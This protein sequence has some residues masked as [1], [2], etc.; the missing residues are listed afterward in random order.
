MVLRSLACA[1]LACACLRP[2]PVVRAP[3]PTPAALLLVLDQEHGGEVRDTPESL[4]ELVTAELVERNLVPEVASVRGRG[5]EVVRDSERRLGKLLLGG[6][7]PLALLVETKAVY[8]SPMN[9]RYRWMVHTRLTAAR[10]DRP[11]ARLSRTLDLSAFVD[12]E[13]EREDRAV[14]SVAATIA[15]AAG[16]LLDELLA[17]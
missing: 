12:F 17:D 13:H 9:G 6:E 7:T 15:E 8:Y 1:A 11:E 14:A 10:R 5:F 3:G 2:A 4:A 16:A